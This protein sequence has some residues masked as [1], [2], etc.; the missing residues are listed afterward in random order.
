MSV[1]FK[2]FDGLKGSGNEGDI[3][4][5]LDVLFLEQKRLMEGMD[6][7]RFPP[8]LYFLL[9][10]QNLQGEA[11]EASEFWGDVTKPWK[12]KYEFDVDHVR[13]E[14]I[15]VL[16]FWLQG[17]I[18]LGLG[19]EEVFEIYSAKHAKNVQRIAEKMKG[20]ETNYAV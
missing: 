10:T 17:A 6:Y 2:Q 8:D 5:S 1:Y 12:E 7:K 18:I 20:N 15:D 11:V 19:A 13:E 3:F 9:T 16:F 4:D 14:W